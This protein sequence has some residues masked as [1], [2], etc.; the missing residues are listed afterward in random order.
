MSWRNTRE[1]RIWRAGVIRRDIRC[2]LCNTL[3]ER[4]AHHINHATYFIDERFDVENGICLCRTCHSHFHN[5]YIGSTR[6]MCIRHDLEE[7]T[8]IA[9]YFKE[10]GKNGGIEL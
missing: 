6:K 1:Y 3:Q 10:K 5:D 8:K 7:Y 9:I 2:Q 4:H